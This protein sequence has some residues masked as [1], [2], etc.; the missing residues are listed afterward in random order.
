MWALVILLAAGV[1]KAADKNVA[2]STYYSLAANMLV[3]FYI[4]KGIFLHEQER[5]FAVT[6]ICF[7]AII[8]S[9]L[10]LFETFWA[11]NPLY[12]F[13]IDNI[14]YERYISEEVRPMSTLL[15]PAALGTYLL[16]SGPFS[17]FFLKQQERPKKILGAVTL[18][19][20]MT[21]FFLA[22][23]RGSFAGLIAMALFY[24]LVEKDRERLLFYG[25]LFVGFLCVASFL[26]YP[27]SRFSLEGIF[28][29]GTGFFSKYRSVRLDMAIQMFRD[30]PFLGIGLNHF[31][32]LFDHYYPL[33]SQVAD[34]LWEHKIADNMY[35]TLLAETG[36]AGIAGF[37]IFIS[38][39][40]L[41]GIRKLGELEKGSARTL[42]LVS[43]S[44]LAGFLT[45]M[46]GYEVLYWPNLYLFF[47]LIC[48]FIQGISGNR[49]GTGAV[50]HG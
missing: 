24:L 12:T 44:S 11:F 19:L 15:N 37:L 33:K 36:L 13:F 21:C 34:I 23:S 4:G 17:I 45:D 46:N 43:L 50:P 41:R 6:V 40:F 9:L 8:V 39:L 31:R 48:G 7:Y 28:I 49:E 2:F 1:L 14:F 26:P 16:L 30:S 3:A 38:S 5:D 29:H 42:L 35:L 47:C 18:T 22:L 10:G 20:V 32:V 25:L 27:F